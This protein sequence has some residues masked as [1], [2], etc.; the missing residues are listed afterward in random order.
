MQGYSE[1]GITG[2]ATLKNWDVSKRL[3]EIAVPTLMI[4]G[5]Y[6]TMD[7]NYMEWMSRQVLQGRS[8]TLNSGHLVQFDDPKNYF[9]GLINFLKEVD[10]GQFK[11]D[12]K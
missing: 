11:P 8:L 12:N 4:G 10:C 2:N 5:K 6:D 7:P 9:N 1:F 3:K